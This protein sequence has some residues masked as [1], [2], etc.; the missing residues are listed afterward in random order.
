VKSGEDY[1]S[2]KKASIFNL[3]WGQSGEHLHTTGKLTDEYGEIISDMLN[4][5]THYMDNYMERYYNN[6]IK[7]IHTNKYLIMLKLRVEELDELITLTER[8][9][10]VM[11]YKEALEE[12]TNDCEIAP[13]IEGE[14]DREMWYKGSLKEA[15]RDATKEATEKG[16]AE[17][18]E[19]GIE[20]GIERGMNEAKQVIA[21]SLLSRGME[22]SEIASITNLSIE[23]IE[24]LKNT[25]ISE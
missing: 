5:N 21:I 10:I 11:E 4:Y 16:L 15:V 3:V 20:Q 7:F 22:L 12:V 18:I 23:I 13:F 19:K 6:D 24:E 14:R 1:L 8:D 9:E 17:G 2:Y 25:I